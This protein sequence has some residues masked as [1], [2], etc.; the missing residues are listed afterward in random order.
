MHNLCVVV[1]YIND[2]MITV[3]YTVYSFYTSKACMGKLNGF[4]HITYQW[5]EWDDIGGDYSK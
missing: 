1:L 4:C 2:R 5:E 3:L